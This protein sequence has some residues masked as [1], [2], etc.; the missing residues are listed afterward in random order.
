MREQI[1]NPKIHEAYS[2]LEQI[3]ADPQTRE[4]AWQRHTQ[5]LNENSELS[6][7]KREGREEGRAEGRVEGEKKG[8]AKGREEGRVEG[9]AEGA[10]QTLQSLRD[11][12][13]LSDAQFEEQRRKLLGEDALS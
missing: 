13:I 4:L 5:K 9:R 7:A 12:G 8:L 6:S 10:L 11:A 3:S 2:V 1:Q